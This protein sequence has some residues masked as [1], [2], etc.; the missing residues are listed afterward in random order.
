MWGGGKLIGKGNMWSEAG[1]HS[2]EQDVPRVKTRVVQRADAVGI[3]S[4]RGWSFCVFE[5]REGKCFYCGT[6]DFWTSYACGETIACRNQRDAISPSLGPHFHVMLEEAPVT[7]T[8]WLFHPVFLVAQGLGQGR[9]AGISQVPK[10]GQSRAVVQSTLACG[11][12]LGG[13]EGRRGG[14]LLRDC[15]GAALG[16]GLSL[17]PRCGA[18]RAAAGARVPAPA[19]LQPLP[20]VR[21]SFTL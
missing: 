9:Q 2:R 12:L 3:C 7:V 13:R 15:V 5:G 19:S 16:V 14:L 1:I 4:A 18:L 10:W 6:R 17:W 20:G 11:S 21:I 8:R